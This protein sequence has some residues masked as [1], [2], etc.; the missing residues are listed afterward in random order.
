MSVTSS[1]SALPRPLV[2]RP[3]PPQRP[4]RVPCPPLPPCRGGWAERL[5]EALTPIHAGSPRVTAVVG[6][7]VIYQIYP[8]S[9]RDSTATASATCPASPPRCASW[10]QLGVDAIWLSPFFRS[11]QR[12][13][14]YDVSDY[15]AVDPLFGT[16][17]D[18]DD[19]VAT[20]T[21]LGIRVIVDLVPNHCSDQHRS[22]RRPSR[23]P[24]AAPSG[25]C[26]SSAT[27]TGTRRTAAEQLAVPLRRLR[28]DPHHRPRRDPR[29]VVPAPLR[30]HP[31]RLQL[32]QP[33]GP[34]EFERILRFWLDRGVGGFRVDVAHALIKATG[35]PD[36]GGRADGG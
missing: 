28:L 17:D 18:F 16:L 36:W 32:G 34:R 22:S 26:S 20:A 15:C 12:D 19:L 1:N 27:A 10:P 7:S 21:G 9:F 14:G 24:P 2:R 29:P 11:P 3:L 13:A 8:R 5:A 33:R 23:A 31:A 6:R 30:L 25:T 35:L 4:Q